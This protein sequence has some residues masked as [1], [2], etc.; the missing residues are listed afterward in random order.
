VPVTC[1][2]KGSV[3]EAAYPIVPVAVCPVPSDDSPCRRIFRRASPQKLRDRHNARRRS[4]LL[5]HRSCLSREKYD[6]SI[7][8]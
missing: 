7:P 3:C 4:F 8:K 2:R 5:D 6:P 1:V